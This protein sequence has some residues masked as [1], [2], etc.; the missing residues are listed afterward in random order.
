MRGKTIYSPTNSGPVNLND[1]EYIATDVAEELHNHVFE[2]PFNEFVDLIL[3]GPAPMSTAIAEDKAQHDND[4]RVAK[5]YLKHLADDK[6]HHSYFAYIDGWLELGANI[7]WLH[8]IVDFVEEV[9][10]HHYRESRDLY[11]DEQKEAE[12]LRHFTFVPEPFD[13]MTEEDE[14]ETSL[15]ISRSLQSPSPQPEVRIPVLL[16]YDDRIT[17]RQLECVARRMLEAT[18]GTRNFSYAFSISPTGLRVWRW[19]PAAIYVS[20]VLDWQE[21]PLGFVMLIQRLASMSMQELGFDER[22]GAPLRPVEGDP[23][24]YLDLVPSRYEKNAAPS[25]GQMPYIAE[26][27]AELP[28][29]FLINYTMST[30][31]SDSFFGHRTWTYFASPRPSTSF[32]SVAIKQTWE[33]ASSTP[34]PILHARVDGMTGVP[35]MS[36]FEVGGSTRSLW[37]QVSSS[38]EA[39]YAFDSS[40]WDVHRNNVVR[41]SVVKDG[42]R[43]AL[44]PA[45]QHY[46]LTRMVFKDVGAPLTKLEDPLDL[47][48]VLRDSYEGELF[49]WI[50]SGGTRLI[51]WL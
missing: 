32:K 37:D 7:D 49:F 41:V 23:P 2:I 11:P 50:H 1:E 27:T 5:A 8:A 47:L 38:I 34:E 21:N 40:G 20:G 24:R 18:D 28:R 12:P 3:Y 14:T 22:F 43:S 4:R 26:P 30:P 17:N 33:P 19:D 6:A 45:I 46:V 39:Y 29:R 48:Y 42:T 44:L 9:A 15:T 10:G 16:A 35:A 25:D 31:S 36:A 13:D 51:S